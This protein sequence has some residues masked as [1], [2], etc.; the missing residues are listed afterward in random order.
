[1]AALSY[2]QKYLEAFGLIPNQ[3][4]SVVIVYLTRMIYLYITV[5][6]AMLPYILYPYFHQDEPESLIPA[7]AATFAF[8][9]AP[10]AYSTF[11]LEDYRVIDTLTTI[12]TLMNDRKTLFHLLTIN[13][14]LYLMKSTREIVYFSGSKSRSNWLY[15]KA[16]RKSF[17]VTKWPF[18]VFSLNFAG[19]SVIIG[20][21]QIFFQWLSGDMDPK[22]LKLVYNMR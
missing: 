13:K 21:K 19:N 16:E 20:A 18:P 4:G 2:H 3:N 22:H 1:M 12:R 6:Q 14:S 7:L 9:I 15:A 17:L 10:L 8:I 11:C 5:I